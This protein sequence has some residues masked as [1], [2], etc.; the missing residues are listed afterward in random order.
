MEFVDLPCDL[1]SLIFQEI[2]LDDLYSYLL[3]F[4]TNSTNAIFRVIEAV[5]YSRLIVTNS[6]RG[7]LK[8]LARA[9][10]IG[11]LDLLSKFTYVSIEYFRELTSTLESKLHPEVPM[12][13]SIIYVVCCD[14]TNVN[15]RYMIMRQFSRILKTMPPVILN[16]SREVYFCCSSLDLFLERDLDEEVSSALLNRIIMSQDIWSS[17]EK[18]TLLGSATAHEVRPDGLPKICFDFSQFRALRS[19]HLSHLGIEDL[20]EVTIPHNVK[21]LNLSNNSI[22]CLPGNILPR[23]VEV[24]DLSYNNLTALFGHK[25]PK[26][27]RVLNL[28]RNFIGELRRLPDSIRDLDISFNELPSAMC[29]IPRSLVVLWTDIAQFYLMSESVQKELRMQQV[30]IKKNIAVHTN[31]STITQI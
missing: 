15:E 29:N 18:L 6:W 20:T 1:L 26:S 19:L 22:K 12:K 31:D 10:Q 17:L 13:R 25:L 24:L 2:D 16:A 21:E 27:L 8:L 3:L 23:H 30:C 5:R 28:R 9:K 7:L 11:P 14:N 4:P